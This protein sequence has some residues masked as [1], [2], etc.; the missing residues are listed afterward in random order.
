MNK[1]QSNFYFQCFERKYLTEE[2]Q[3]DNVIISSRC[4]VRDWEQFYCLSAAVYMVSAE[5]VGLQLP[6]L[7]V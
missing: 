4:N 7:T 1:I 5:P 6:A 3:R 2:K